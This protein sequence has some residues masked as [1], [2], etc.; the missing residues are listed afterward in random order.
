MLPVAF[1]IRDIVF[2]NSVILVGTQIGMMLLLLCNLN[3]NSSL[4]R[5]AKDRKVMTEEV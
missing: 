4:A 2:A 5:L 1:H 3:A